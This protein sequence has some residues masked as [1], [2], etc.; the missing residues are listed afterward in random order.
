MGRRRIDIVLPRDF[1]QKSNG[2]QYEGIPS[3]YKTFTPGV[4]RFCPTS[5]II[6]L[7]SGT[8]KRGPSGFQ[9]QWRLSPE[10]AQNR[11]EQRTYF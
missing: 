3:K 6:I 5:N 1:P 9:N 4:K 11:G 8:R 2:P 10:E 7:G